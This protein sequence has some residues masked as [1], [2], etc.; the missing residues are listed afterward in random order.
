VREAKDSEGGTLDEMSN[1]GEKE[2][3]EF[4]FSRTTGH[5]V[6]GWDCHPIV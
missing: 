1:S 6:E 2:L 3:V 4:T 5:Q